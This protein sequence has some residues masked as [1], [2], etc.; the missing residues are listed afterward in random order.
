L[1]LIFQFDDTYKEKFSNEI[2]TNIWKGVLKRSIRIYSLPESV[3]W[4]CSD[5]NGDEDEDDFDRP[6]RKI[7]QSEIEKG[8]CAV[9]F[10]ANYLFSNLSGFNG[11]H[12]KGKQNVLFGIGDLFEPCEFH[13]TCTKL[14]QYVFFEERNVGDE[15][16]CIT[17]FNVSVQFKN[18]LNCYQSVFVY[19]DIDEGKIDSM[20]N[21][22]LIQLYYDPISRSAIVIDIFPEAFENLIVDL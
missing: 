2:L 9:K 22:N 11:E 18:N 16:E 20:N 1:S 14:N 21:E 6:N 5:S 19:N 13:A 3:Y 7:T 8:T 12:V 4:N 10:V 17:Y 15:Y